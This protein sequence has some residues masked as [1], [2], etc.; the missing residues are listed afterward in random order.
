M[1][2][3][4]LSGAL[5]ASALAVL[6]AFA[7][8]ADRPTR[9]DDDTKLAGYM[10]E[11]NTGLRALRSMLREAE[12]NGESIAAVRALQLTITNARSEKPTRTAELPEDQ[13]AAYALE[14]QRQMLDFGMKVMELEAALL[15]GDNEAAQEVWKAVNAM[16]SPA[17]EK[18]KVKD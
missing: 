16:K 7:P 17:H 5:L 18:F 8:P 1:I 13:R 3:R 10:K 2:H 11:I 9:Q 14:Y 12:R 15:D 6:V 4:I